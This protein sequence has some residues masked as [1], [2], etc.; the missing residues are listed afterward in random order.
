MYTILLFLTQWYTLIMIWYTLK[1]KCD[2]KFIGTQ[3][4]FDAFAKLK[5]YVKKKEQKWLKLDEGNIYIYIFL[6]NLLNS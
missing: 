2:W 5:Q 4:I 1:R 6:V 3:N